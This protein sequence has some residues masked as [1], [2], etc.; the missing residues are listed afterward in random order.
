MF[1]VFEGGE[2]CG[3]TTLRR[4]VSEKLQTMGHRVVE[5]REP[6][7]TPMAEEIREV[8]LDVREEPVEPLTEALLFF[9]GRNQHIHYTVLPALREGAVV[10]CD[11][12]IDSSFA[13]QCRGGEL[14]SK[15][16]DTLVEMTL[17]RLR[18]DVTVVLDH[19]PAITFTNVL[20]REFVDRMELKGLDYHNRV[21]QGFLDQAKVDTSRY[22]VLAAH[23]DLDTMVDT[24]IK[25]MGL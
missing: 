7:G 25:R 3:K 1:V 16:F 17:G 9:A 8:L 6:G 13:L 20:N 23:Q 15:H 21:R 22:M 24:V 5:T 11:R 18:P 4:A 2:G 19:D 12:F 10:L 14:S